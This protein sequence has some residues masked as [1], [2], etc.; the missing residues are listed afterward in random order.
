MPAAPEEPL[1]ERTRAALDRMLAGKRFVF[2]GEP[3]HFIVE[4]YPFRLTLIRHLF[5]RRWQRQAVARRWFGPS[6]I[7]KAFGLAAATQILPV[8]QTQ[9]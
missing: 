4:K 3:D 7:G 6:A 1:G 5:A 9:S 2:L 8:R